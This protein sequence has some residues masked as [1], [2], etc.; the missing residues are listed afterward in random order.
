MNRS[1][2]LKV[3]LLLCALL[4]GLSFTVQV[5]GAQT[6]VTGLDFPGTAGTSIRFRWTNPQNLGLPIYGPSGQG[7]TYIWRAY[8]RQKAS[9]YT[10]FFWANDDG[11]CNLNAW[12]WDNGSINTTY[13]AHPYPDPPPNGTEHYWEIAIEGQDVVNPTH[14]VYNR[15][16][17]QAFRVWGAPGSVKHHEYYYDL[18]DTSKVITYTTDRSSWG[19]KL[20][21]GPA[22]T[23]GDAPHNCGGETYSGI[24]RGFQIYNTLLST[25]EI[26]QEIDTPFSSAKAGSIWYL[27]LNPT[28]SD[29]SDKSGKGHQP[30]WVGSARPALYGDTSIPAPAAPTNVRII[31]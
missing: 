9:Y 10:T 11:S 3:L 26:S 19:D 29:I 30:A 5:P 17:T 6:G 22:L 25:A 27:N 24:L 4:A 28:P 1:P 15:W 14:I 23:F 13:G 16:Y 20:P 2:G 31:P 18:P 12:F 8:P 7:V 21:P